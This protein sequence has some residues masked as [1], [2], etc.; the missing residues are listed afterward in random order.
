MYESRNQKIQSLVVRGVCEKDGVT[1]IVQYGTKPVER[2]CGSVRSSLPAL[3]RLVTIGSEAAGTAFFDPRDEEI[4]V[5]RS[6][7]LRA[8]MRS[9]GQ[10]G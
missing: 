1:V 10:A 5:R 8:S 3:A 7:R 6:P 9:E 2:T 4:A